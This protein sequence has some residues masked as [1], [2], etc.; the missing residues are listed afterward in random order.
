M[1]ELPD[2]LAFVRIDGVPPAQSARLQ[3]QL[4]VK[5]GD[6]L[7]PDR[8]EEDLRRLVAV[9]DYV[10]LD[11]RLEPAPGS[12]GEGLV[13]QLLDDQ[14]VRHQLRLGLDLQTD[15]QGQGDFRLRISHNQRD[16]TAH[17]GQWRN[18][19][20]LGATVAAGTE[21]YLPF[22]DNRNRFFS[23]HADHELRKIEWFDRDGDPFALFRRR[24]SRI[25][26]DVGWHLG[27][28]GDWG[29]VRF[30]P[31]AARRQSLVDYANTTLPQSTL[32][33]LT[34]TEA[35]WRLA[36]VSDQLDHA[37]FP[38]SGHR[39]TLAWETGR[40]RVER[41]RTGYRRWDASLN[42]VISLGPHT[43]NTY[44]RLGYSSAL[45]PGAPDEYSLGGFQQLSGYRVG[46]VAGNS[47]VLAR[48]GYYQRLPVSPGVARA[49]FAGGTVEVGN[50]WN[51]SDRQDPNRL[52]KNLRW[53]SSL[54]VGA[55][56]GIGPVYLSLVYA[57]RGYT[58]VYFLLGKP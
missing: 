24:T 58:G 17:G 45:P 33:N 41:A 8:V 10:R 28:I 43:W 15:F 47:L 30:G 42:E 7:A 11:Y 14:A 16:T 40:Y 39:Y 38:Q 48:L 50:A 46:Q 5:P 22:G 31:T 13:Y 49:L 53:G 1:A 37:N 52:G 20:E 21:L 57:P 44:L 27:R 32:R 4:D 3:R 23:L 55:D 29:D 25:G 51:S 9:D 19:L 6:P 26:L 18:R 34:W 36:W 54:Y 56:T 2:A 35:G 12:G